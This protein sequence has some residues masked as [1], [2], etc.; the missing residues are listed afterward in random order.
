MCFT[1][2]NSCVIFFSTIPDTIEVKEAVVTQFKKLVYANS[3]QIFSDENR[4]FEELVE[5][6]EVRTNQKYV[7]LK[8]YYV[9]NWESCQLMWVRCFRISLPLLGDNTTN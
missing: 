2:L 8:D 5:N 9:K 3:E 1:L 7:N 4:K 6:F